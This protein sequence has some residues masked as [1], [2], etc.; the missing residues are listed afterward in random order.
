MAR[1]NRATL[2]SSSAPAPGW[3]PQ[4]RL[5]LDTA[6]PAAFKELVDEFEEWRASQPRPDFKLSD[7]WHVNTPQMAEQILLLNKK[8]ANR[9]AALS[10]CLYYFKQM[11]RGDWQETGQ[12]VI[13]DVDGDLDDGQHREWACYLGGVPFT[14]YV[15]NQTKPLVNAF[16]YIDNGKVRTIKDA[17]Y[18]AGLNGMSPVLSQVVKLADLHEQGALTTGGKRSVPRMS[19]IQGMAFVEARPFLRR[20]V[21]LTAG[22]YS[23]VLTSIVHP[24]VAGYMAGLIIQ[25][26]DEDTLDDFYQGLSEEHDEVGGAFTNFQ[27][28][29]RA[30][31]AKQKPMKKHHVFGH[32]IKTFNYWISDTEVDKRRFGLKVTENFPVL[33][34]PG[35]EVADAGTEDFL[36]AAE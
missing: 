22:E 20:G 13:F 18:T 28:K 23:S 10:T 9:E 26:Y 4:F 31:R 16:A 29:M 17:F 3:E 2:R 14:T 1:T 32:L 11:Q 5:D 34:Q 19:P 7:G 6:K 15:V 12:P 36:D 24:D 33:V 30:D 21:A 27:Q 35:E 25:S 8:G